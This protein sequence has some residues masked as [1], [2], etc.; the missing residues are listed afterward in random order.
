M[1]LG[2]G[3]RTPGSGLQRPGFGLRKLGFGLQKPGFEDLCLKALPGPS[4]AMHLG[5]GFG[6]LGFGLW[7]L[8]FRLWMLGFGHWRLG[9]R[10]WRLGFGLLGT[11]AMLVWS[12][13]AFLP[14]PPDR[15]KIAERR[16]RD[17]RAGKARAKHEPAETRMFPAWLR[18]VRVDGNNPQG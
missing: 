12:A 3:L 1:W 17:R 4:C 5:I 11:P 2:F 6:R 8:G 14:T 15:P 16:R 10:R 9:F 18:Q 7:K 13:S